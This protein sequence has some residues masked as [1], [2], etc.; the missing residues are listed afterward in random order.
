MRWLLVVVVLAAC[1]S[2]APDRDHESDKHVLV[3]SLRK[4]AT[5]KAKLVAADRCYVIR[6]DAL[7]PEIG[8]LTAALA[9]AIAEGGGQGPPLDCVDEDAAE[10]VGYTYVDRALSVNRDELT[11]RGIRAARGTYYRIEL[12]CGRQVVV[13]DVPGTPPIE[14]AWQRLVDTAAKQAGTIGT[15]FLGPRQIDACV[16]LNVR[17]IGTR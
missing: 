8:A 7:R 2:T 9:D 5:G 10:V 6:A 12:L 3:V 16:G 1:S 4:G 11:I 14:G 13:T 15:A 17:D